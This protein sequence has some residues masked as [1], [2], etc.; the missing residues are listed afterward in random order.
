[1]TAPFVEFRNLEGYIKGT[2]TSTGVSSW[3]NKKNVTF[4]SV[5]NGTN[6]SFLVKS[7][8]YVKY[9]R[10]AD[11]AIPKRPDIATLLAQLTMWAG[12]EEMHLYDDKPNTVMQV[13]PLYDTAS[14]NMD[15]VRN[16]TDPYPAGS[17]QLANASGFSGAL[18]KSSIDPSA[19]VVLMSAPRDSASPGPSGSGL[20]GRIS[21]QTKQYAP[22]PADK[23]MVAL[24]TARLVDPGALA[25]PVPFSGATLADLA[26]LVGSVFR[27]GVFDDSYD[28][29]AGFGKS[30][31]GN[32]VFV[33]FGLNPDRQDHL[34]DR[35]A[36]RAI[37][38]F[39]AVGDAAGEAAY[40]QGWKN[41]ALWVVF[42]TSANGQQ[43]D[44][45]YPQSSW[46][47]DR[48]FQEDGSVFDVDPFMFNT[49]V[50][51]YSASPGIDTRFGVMHG[52]MIHWVHTWDTTDEPYRMA[53]SS[54]PIRWEVDNRYGTSNVKMVAGTAIVSCDGSHDVPGRP[55][56]FDTGIVTKELV[57]HE[58][59]PL[60]SFRLSPER[61]RGALHPMRLSLLNKGASGTCKYELRLNPA[62]LTAATWGAGTSYTFDVVSPVV[63]SLSDTGTSMQV[64][65]AATAVSG[66]VTLVSGYLFDALVRDISVDFSLT[67][68]HAAIDG[69][70]D[71]LTL[72]VTLI[73]G[74][75][76]VAASLQFLEKD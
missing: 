25:V 52:S 15:E 51:Q 47:M 56:S 23:R 48:L 29:K 75:V 68:L 55:V 73:A 63:Q 49:F 69:T 26:P 72:V 37:A 7:D 12:E 38:E 22:S 2:D 60:V 21:R 54:L 33:E 45:R 19:K 32:G 18:L 61:N 66:G 8:S 71:V 62:A 50:F 57:R 24:V 11:V 10:W 74:T 27:A 35:E 70:P 17:G 31:A 65:T 13:K 28:V 53:S 42:R 14:M 44:V 34:T 4:Q 9:F 64:D 3:F 46:N 43:E 36:Q 5:D 1:M 59:T 30:V 67:Q 20:G 40:I 76:D 6:D 41:S 58:Q 39:Q 16:D